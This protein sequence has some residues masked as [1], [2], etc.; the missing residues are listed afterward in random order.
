MVP[1]IARNGTSFR[2]AGA[3]HLHDKPTPETPRPRSSARVVF[4]ATRNLANDDP[5]AALD[6][7]WR[8]ARD[9]EHLKAAA[10]VARCGRPSAAPVKT[11]SLAWSPAERPSRAQM[12]EAADSFLRAMGWHEHQAVYAVHG[13]TAHPHLHIILNRVHPAT[14]RMLNDWQER[15]RA[16]AWA[17]RH[18]KQ[19]G[20]V[21][22]PARVE[23][24]EKG[25]RGL[26]A[27]LPY[28]LAKLAGGHAARDVRAQFRP[29]W[30]A[31]YRKQRKALARQA[32]QAVATRSIAASLA[33]EGDS[34]RALALLDGLER[35]RT[36]LTRHLAAQRTA[37]A[38][39]QAR[40][41]RS[42]LEGEGRAPAAGL[43]RRAAPVTAND[44][45]PRLAMPRNLPGPRPYVR[46]HAVASPFSRAPPVSFRTLAALHR[47]ERRQLI[48]LQAAARELLRRHG[49]PGRQASALARQEVALAFANR[50][51]EIERLPPEERAAAAAVLKAEQ[52]AM[53]AAR[54]AYHGSLATTARRTSMRLLAGLHRAER[55]ALRHRHRQAWAAAAA[56]LQARHRAGRVARSRARPQRAQP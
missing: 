31:H 52:A 20:R 35:Q 42:I 29:A 54:L 33:R 1:N 38:V 23:R 55:T 11:M 46:L 12:L 30:A 21:L 50:W 22:C 40:R 14:G 36:A 24:R 53:L 48:A 32:R 27:P 34:A 51:A 37:I 25:K 18:E 19:Q 16:Q 5:H 15:K 8:T 49:R 41:L 2:G 7:M 28:P 13:D 9:A 44:N 47:T 56:G 26:P 17:L 45:A 10:G 4:T 43:P 3:Y 39:A 6:E